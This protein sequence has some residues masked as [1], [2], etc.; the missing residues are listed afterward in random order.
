MTLDA[1]YAGLVA[2]NRYGPPPSAGDDGVRPHSF[3]GASEAVPAGA[4]ELAAK[5]RRGEARG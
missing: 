4:L 1:M 2:H 3:E 5:R